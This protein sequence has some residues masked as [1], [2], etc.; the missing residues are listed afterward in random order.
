[1][2]YYYSQ[3]LHQGVAQ[4]AL[5]AGWSLNTSNYRS[6]MLPE[7]SWDGI[8]GC[9]QEKDAYYTEFVK[10]R[11]IPAVSLTVSDELPSVLPDNEA[12]GSMAA[13]HLLE[14]GYK[15]VAF[16]FWQ[17]TRH[18]LERAESLEKHLAG[19]IRS[20]YR[21]NYAA[22]PRIRLQSMESR[23]RSAR[24]RLEKLPKP[25]AI[26]APMDDLAVEILEICEDMKLDVPGEVGV[27]GVNNDDLICNFTTV[28]LSSID[29][30]EW[31]IGYEGAALLDRI[32]SGADTPERPVLIPPN[33]VHVRK[34]TDL[35]EISDVSNRNVAAA[36]RFISEH[37]GE[38]IT[39]NDVAVS[40]SLSKRHLQAVFSRHV[41]RTVHDQIM[42]K[43]IQH[44]KTTLRM[45]DLK[46]SCVATECGFRS[47]E[48]FSRSFKQIAGL[49][50][51]EY[52][53]I[54]S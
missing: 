22:K 28:P 25:I 48:G 47:R 13:D 24:R 19:G 51:A 3:S 12:I 26:M 35:L 5:E 32:M 9:F 54:E 15:N 11:G 38:P 41:G 42:L 23:L 44:A 20:F 29:D 50:P 1:M 18:E 45:T 43:R 4:Y 30:N 46:I 27:L 21:I 40:S 52:R 10:P 53:R 37:F 6:G 34:S 36:L 2:Q 8:V 14:L 39:T 49:T 33:G 7:R 16:Y 31:K 17:S